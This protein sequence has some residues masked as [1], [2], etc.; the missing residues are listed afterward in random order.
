M[1]SCVLILNKELISCN[2]VINQEYIENRFFKDDILKE[3]PQYIE[4]HNCVFEKVTFEQI[5]T[6]KIFQ[7]VVFKE[8][9]FSNVKMYS[10]SFVSVTF[11]HCNMIGADFSCSTFLNTK[12]YHCLAHYS[13]FNQVIWK[14]CE[15]VEN[16]FLESDFSSCKLERTTFQLCRLIKTNFHNTSLRKIDFRNNEIVGIM[17]GLKELDGLIV[18]SNQATIFFPLLGLTIKEENE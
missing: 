11:D 1:E 10:S 18:T 2:D 7:N 14:A 5:Q 6:E 12:I 8:C 3:L 4:F 17:V 9:N 13:N 15:L 16:D